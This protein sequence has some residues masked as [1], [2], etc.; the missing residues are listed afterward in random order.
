[1]SH[2]VEVDQSGKVED[3]AKDTVLV[4]TDGESY[5]ILIPATVKRAVYR[6][7]TNRGLREKEI[8]VQLFSVGLYF[9][10]R[11]HITNLQQITIDTEYTGKNT[12]IKERLV[13][14]L[15]RGHYQV[16]PSQISFGHVGKRSPAHLLGIS[17]FRKE[18]KADLTLTLEQVLSEFETRS[19]KRE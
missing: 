8:T 3:T 19:R 14:Y 2:T 1:M 17:V 7:L 12:L 18:R 11:E 15:L 16:E 5:S 6:E 13:S 4:F 9:L 10:L